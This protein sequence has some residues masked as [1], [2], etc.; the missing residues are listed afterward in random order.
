MLRMSVI[1][2]ISLACSL[3]APS[4]H[5]DASAT[6]TKLNS[7][8]Q[9]LLSRLGPADRARLREAQRAWIAFRDKECAFRSQG[10]DA[11]SAGATVVA[12]CITE[13]TEARTSQLK[14]QLDCPEGDIACVPRNRDTAANADPA[15]DGAACSKSAGAS[16]AETLVKQ[17]LEVSPATHPPCNAANSCDLITDEIARGCAMLRKNA[18]SFCAEYSRGGH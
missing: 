7:V 8:Y 12:G 10:T 18:P 13:L 16:K 17:C 6:D 9:A 4:A 1:L 11:G 14:A 15:A 5:A 3:A 2:A